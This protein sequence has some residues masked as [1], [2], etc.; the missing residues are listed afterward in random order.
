MS[1]P[2][3]AST[4]DLIG[5]RMRAL[6]LW[7]GLPGTVSG[8]DHADP[9][10][11]ESSAANGA[12][13]IAAVADGLLAL[14]GQDWNASRWA[15]GLR[16]PGT[17]E[18]DVIAAFDRGLLVR[19]W[20]MRGTIH[21]VPAAD[22]G[23]MQAVTNHRVLPTAPKRRHYLG[24]S[25]EALAGMTDVAVSRLE[26]GRS[27]SRDELGEAWVQA[28]YGQGGQ[29]LGPWRYHLIWWLCQNGIVTAGP[30]SDEASR[31]SGETTGSSGGADPLGGNGSIPE[32]R[33]VL[34]EEWIVR[35][36]RLEGDEALT[37]LATRFVRGRGPVH[38]RDFAWWSGLTV[39]EARAALASAA[40]DERITPVE[41]EG[42][43]HWAEPSLLAEP[44]SPDA[45]TEDT[46]LLPGFD[47][48]LLGYTERGAVLDPAHF[49][50]IVPGRNGMFKATVVQAGRVVGTWART[51]RTR[52]TLIEAE[53][54]PGR[55]IEAA[56]LQPHAE[57]WGRFRGTEVR[58][59]GL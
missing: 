8:S 29:G 17:T 21:V 12:D 37:E 15:L 34:A 44:T 58:V 6:G 2:P 51:P 41:V 53:P 27:A 40:A 11:A 26:G 23:W 46:L 30:V 50:R 20:P 33:L 47:E 14:Q 56:A 5:W 57:A 13:R 24:I 7:R 49:E 9:G 31:A 25:D 45:C 59:A 36:R 52:H 18:H 55:T 38:E 1:A 39:R 22:I 3:K 10:G 43:Q 28:G 54:L 19:S 48:H 4:N 16:A 32:P 42:V 35:P